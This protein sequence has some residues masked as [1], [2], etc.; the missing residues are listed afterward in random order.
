MQ[1]VDGLDSITV[2]AFVA[3]VDDPNRFEDYKDV[4]AYVSLTPTQ[5]SSGEIKKQGGILKKKGRNTLGA[6]L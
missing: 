4:A 5:Y 3:E 6:Y 1:T 2:L